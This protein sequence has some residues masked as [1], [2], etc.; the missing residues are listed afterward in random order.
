[1]RVK[2]IF[3]EN[4]NDLTYKVNE[5]LNLNSDKVITSIS[6]AMPRDK[7]GAYNTIVYSDKEK[8][9]EKID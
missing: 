2:V 1:M 4:S 7:D 6:P 9:F 3:G 8:I 5:W